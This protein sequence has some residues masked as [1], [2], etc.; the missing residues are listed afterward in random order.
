[1]IQLEKIAKIVLEEKDGK[2]YYGGSLDLQGTGIT[3]LPD[4]LTVGDYLDLQDTG[5]A[6]ISNITR[7]VIQYFEWQ[8]G[9]YIKIDGIF[10]EVIS[11]KN[12][13][14]KVRQIASTKETYMVTDGN[15]KFSHGETIKEAKADLIYKIGNRDKSEYTSLTPT[16]KLTFEKAV[17]CYRVIT[18]ACGAGVKGFVKSLPDVK[19][20]YIIQEI[21]DL[22][23]GNYGH[24]TFTQFFKK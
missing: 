15:G 8:N 17:E 9:K 12:K 19:K 16:S 5:I 18:G 20:S 6:D 1:M 23:K 7:C 21:I 4:N 2:K 24:E 13:I 3:S 14:W 11:K 10:S 22:T